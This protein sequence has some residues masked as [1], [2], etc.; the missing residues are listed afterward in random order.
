[1]RVIGRRLN[2][3]RV[4]QDIP[5]ASLHSRKVNTSSGSLLCKVVGVAKCR[6][7]GYVFGYEC[8]YECIMVMSR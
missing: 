7:F 3:G 1:M 2:T 5:A 6:C 4:H 8:G